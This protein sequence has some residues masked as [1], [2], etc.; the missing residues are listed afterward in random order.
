MSLFLW[1]ALTSAVGLLQLCMLLQ[2]SSST[3][4][5]VLLLEGCHPSCAAFKLLAP[6]PP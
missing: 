3:A 5:A 1:Q 2:H 4:V 6:R